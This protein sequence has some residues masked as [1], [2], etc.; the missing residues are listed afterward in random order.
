MSDR[1]YT[2]RDNAIELALTHARQFG[3]VAERSSDASAL[4][5]LVAFAD[6]RLVAEHER[7]EKLVAYRE[8]AA[9]D[10]RREAIYA[11]NLQAIEDGIL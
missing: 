1:L 9:D 5:A 6:E 3:L 10:E 8:L 4:H 2:R 11:S 7:E